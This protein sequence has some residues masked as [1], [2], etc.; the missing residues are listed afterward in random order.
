MRIRSLSSRAAASI[1]LT[2][3]WETAQVADNTN[4]ELGLSCGQRSSAA[5]IQSDQPGEHHEARAHYNS[6]GSIR[7]FSPISRD[8]ARRSSLH[9]RARSEA[10][11]VGKECV[12]VDQAG[13]SQ[14]T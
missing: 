4:D 7:T 3:T 11:R 10:L 5:A 1:C 12:S 9:F 2:R 14:E 6:A 8:P 13:G